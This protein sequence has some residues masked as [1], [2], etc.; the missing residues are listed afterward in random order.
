MLRLTF[1]RIDLIRDIG[2]RRKGHQEVKQ[3][4]LIVDTCDSIEML[5]S[6]TTGTEPFPNS[7]TVVYEPSAWK[8]CP[9][10][11]SEMAYFRIVNQ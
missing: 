4:E 1:W 10:K 3:F 6:L 7:N 11:C 5:P 2:D 9:L 8:D